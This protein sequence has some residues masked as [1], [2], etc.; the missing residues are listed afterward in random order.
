VFEPP[1]IVSH[2]AVEMLVPTDVDHELE[3]QKY[4]VSTEDASPDAV[5]PAHEIA[6]VLFPPPPP[7]FRFTAGD[8]AKFDHV[9]LTNF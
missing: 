4:T 2:V 3:S 7:D 6:P 9:P 8:V 5:P 1:P